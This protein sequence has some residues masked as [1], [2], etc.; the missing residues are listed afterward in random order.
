[1]PGWGPKY[2]TSAPHYGAKWLG[3]D[4]AEKLSHARIQ[5][6]SYNAELKPFSPELL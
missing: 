1:V 5:G 4:F 2:L 3:K 6:A